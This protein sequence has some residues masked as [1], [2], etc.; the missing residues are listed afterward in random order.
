MSNLERDVMRSVFMV[1]DVV[2]DTVMKTI[3][4]ASAEGKIERLSDTDL[5]QLD[6]LVRS[7]INSALQNGTRQLQ[8][9]VKAHTK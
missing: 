2:K 5:R 1:G 6:N 4:E 8:S 7:S 9:V 3:I